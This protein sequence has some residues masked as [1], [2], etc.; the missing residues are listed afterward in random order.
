MTFLGSWGNFF[1][2]LI[3]ATKDAVKT[4]PVGIAQ[5][6]LSEQN[7]FEFGLPDFGIQMAGATFSFIPMFI[8]FCFFQKY[9]V[10]NIFAGS[11]KQ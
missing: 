4:L 5:M 7:Y 6:V 9:F 3:I 10:Q 1:W 8:I 11:I 2:Q